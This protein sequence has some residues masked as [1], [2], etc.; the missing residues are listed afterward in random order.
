MN[1]STTLKPLLAFVALLAAVVA[2]PVSAATITGLVNTGA[3]SVAGAQDTNYSLTLP[4][5]TTTYG[6]EAPGNDWPITPWLANTTTSQWLMP[7]APVQG[8]DNHPAGIYTWLLS[9]DLTGFKAETASF[10]GRWSTDNSGIIKL[11]GTTLANSASTSFEQWKDF[12]ATRGFLAG[13]NTLEF[14][15][16][17]ASGAT[18]NPAGLRVEFTDSNVSAVPLPAAIWMFGSALLGFMGLSNR[19]KI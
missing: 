9:F 8:R 18:G 17:N 2:T 4:N 10:S 19:R 1:A 6:Y 12:S 15:L 14:V 7:Y 16:T 5:S 3:S 11:N 13:L